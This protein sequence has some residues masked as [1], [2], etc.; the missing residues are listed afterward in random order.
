MIQNRCYTI[1]QPIRTAPPLTRHLITKDRD[2][3]T[4]VSILHATP[5]YPFYFFFFLVGFLFPIP[6]PKKIFKR[7]EERKRV[8]VSRDYHFLYISSSSALHT[9][10][11][12]EEVQYQ[13]KHFKKQIVD[14]AE[15]S[16][17]VSLGDNVRPPSFGLGTPFPTP[18]RALLHNEKGIGYLQSFGRVKSK[19]TRKLNEARDQAHRRSLYPMSRTGGWSLSTCNRPISARRLTQLF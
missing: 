5:L 14:L 12:E 4:R 10:T 9:T 11:A 17:F 19:I 8:P 18:N 2:Q 16:P 3:F 1:V 6:T 7:F 13:H 15:D